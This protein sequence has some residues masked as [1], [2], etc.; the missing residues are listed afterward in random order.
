M[1]APG[2]RSQKK[3]C[4]RK[5]KE[6][7]GPATQGTARSDHVLT[8]LWAHYSIDTETSIHRGEVL[9]GDKLEACLCNYHRLRMLNQFFTISVHFIIYCTASWTLFLSNFLVD[10]PIGEKSSQVSTR[11]CQVCS[12]LAIA[13]NQHRMMLTNKSAL[14]GWRYPGP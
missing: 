10:Q 7:R 2:A 3:P 5:E 9:S 1:G 11:S 14:R 13:P 6:T 12:L 4:H 8:Q